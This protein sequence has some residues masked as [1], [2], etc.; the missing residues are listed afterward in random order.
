MKNQLKRCVNIQDLQKQ[1]QRV[2]PSPVLGYLEGGADDEYSLNRN[3]SAY[4]SHELI[5]R[6]LNDVSQVNTQI[7]VLGTDIDIPL[8][9]APTGMSRLFHEEAEFAVAKAAESVRTMY[10]LSTVATESI[11]SIANISKGPKMFQLYVFGDMGLNKEFIHRCKS[12][13]YQALCLT[14][15]VPTG[16]NRERDIRTGMALPPKFTLESKLSLLTHPSW[17]I[18]RLFGK[19]FDLPNVSHLFDGEDKDLSKRMNFIFK[20]LSPTVTWSDA[21]AMI[22]EWDG[23][24]AI[25]G[26]M[27]PSDARKAIDIGA[28]AI[29]VSNHGGRQLDTV[30]ATFDCLTDIVDAVNNRAEVILDGGI[31]RGTDVL[32]ALALG[33]KACMIGRP[34]L[35]GLS[36]AGQAGVEHAL[37]IF[38]SE[39]ERDLALIGCSDICELDH[40]FIKRR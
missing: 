39:I 17:S 8:M 16:G 29:M 12:A 5:P 11:E 23:P 22:T 30:P 37:N 18:N 3:L 2:L 10:T 14:V 20:Q 7:N 19:A 24:F 33:A 31:R 36:L 1:A 34:Y 38:R 25:K 6:F 40:T 13:G 21:E 27:S 26:I 9:I 32:K 4:N 28:S 15:D 35:Y